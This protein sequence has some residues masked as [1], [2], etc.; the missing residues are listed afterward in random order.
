VLRE[1]SELRKAELREKLPYDERNMV[2]F[3][4]HGF[5]ASSFDMEML[6]REI[7]KM[8]PT[9]LLHCSTANEM[10]TD[11]DISAMGLRLAD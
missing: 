9:A 4:C 7:R 3:F 5:Q 10:D 8:L 11:G 2:V 6:K 1:L